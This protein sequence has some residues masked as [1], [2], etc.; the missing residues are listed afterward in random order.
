M[1]VVTAKCRLIQGKK[2]EFNE[3]AAELITETRKEKGCIEYSLYE[4]VNNEDML[5]FIEKWESEELLQMHIQSK[6][7]KKLVPML[8]ML[9]IEDSIIE[10]YREV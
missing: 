2:N 9:Q 8:R 10:M 1:I 7:F 4:D 6:H 3:L 5:C